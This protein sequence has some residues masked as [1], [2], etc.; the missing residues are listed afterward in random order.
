MNGFQLI[1]A[2]AVAGPGKS[3]ELRHLKTAQPDDV[4]LESLYFRQQALAVPR[5]LSALIYFCPSMDAM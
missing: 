3:N 5:R 4:F 1:A 2:Q